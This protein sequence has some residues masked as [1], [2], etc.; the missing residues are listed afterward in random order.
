VPRSA[1]FSHYENIE[2]QVQCTRDLV[3][4][5]DTTTRQSKHNR[6]VSAGVVLEPFRESAAGLSPVSEAFTHL[7]AV[8]R[9]NAQALSARSLV[10]TPSCTTS[11]PSQLLIDR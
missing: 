2:G 1:E 4:N 10:Q 8:S 6:V 5:R 7:H 3:G 11:G 9:C